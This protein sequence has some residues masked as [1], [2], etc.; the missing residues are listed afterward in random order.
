MGQLYDL[1]SRNDPEKAEEYHKKAIDYFKKAREAKP[2]QI[3]T[4]YWLAKLFHD[5]GDDVR[6]RKVLIP[7]PTL[8]FSKLCPITQEMMD[9]LVKEV[10]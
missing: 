1:M 3:T 9:A 7:A 6:A 10:G 8:Y 4:I 5:D 2:R